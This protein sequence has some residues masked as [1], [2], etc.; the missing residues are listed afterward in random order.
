ML[1]RNGFAALLVITALAVVAAVLSQRGG[2]PAVQGSGEPVLADLLANA[3]RVARVRISGTDG[4]VTLE[5]TERRWEV[6]ER[7]GYAASTER[8]RA[9]ILGLA[10]L[11]RVEP[12]TRNPELYAQLGLGDDAGSG[13]QAASVTLLDGSGET[14]VAIR[15][16]NRRTSPAD[17]ARTEIYVRSPDDPQVWLAE[18]RLPELGDAA[19]WI[20]KTVLDVDARRVRAVK[21]THAD[22]EVVAVSRDDPTVA[23]FTLAGLGEGEE[24]ESSYA[25]NGIV[26]GLRRLSADDV[27]VEGATDAGDGERTSAVLETFDGLRVSVQLVK[28]E[29]GYHGVLSAAYDATLRVEANPAADEIAPAAS[30]ST[31]PDVPAEAAALN[32]RWQGWTYLFP[33]Y[34]IENVT[35]RKADLLKRQAS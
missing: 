7:S 34:A 35:V 5:R 13:A 31:P 9:L 3:N 29:D 33:T 4:T 25:V 11:R 18:G 6:A 23:D 1:T 26:T 14:L 32:E 15:L 30:N 19:A 24:A 2:E 16:G 28:G 21:V 27:L 20:D 17:P 22:G 8:V 10:E 12:K